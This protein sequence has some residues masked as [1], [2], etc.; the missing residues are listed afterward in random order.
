MKF[1]KFLTIGIA[2]LSVAAFSFGLAACVPEN[3]E[4]DDPDT[5]G[6]GTPVTPAEVT[7]E[8]G[9]AYYPPDQGGIGLQLNLY[10][11]GTFYYNQF[12]MT[13]VYGTYSAKE[14]TGTDEEGRTIHYEVTF[15]EGDDFGDETHYIVS[16]SEGSV[17]LTGMYDSMSLGTYEYTKQEEP[18]TEAIQTVEQFWS[19]NY[20][21]D[22]ITATFYSDD[23]YALDGINGAGQAGS[24]GTYT[25]ETAEDG[26]VTYTMTDGDDS[27]KVY[28]ITVVG[29]SI[30][31]KSGETEY[32][33]TS[34]NPMATVAMTLTGSYS[35]GASIVLTCYDDSTCN[36][37]I[38]ME[39]VMDFADATGTWSYMADEDMY[40]F[41]LNGESI[42]TETDGAGTYTLKYKINAAQ[43][44]G[45]EV[46]LTYKNE[47]PTVTY[48]FVY[49]NDWSYD[50]GTEITMTAR[51]EE[52]ADAHTFTGDIWGGVGTLTITLAADGTVVVVAD[53][54]SVG[55]VDVEVTTGTWEAN[56]D[57]SLALTINGNAYT[58][59]VAE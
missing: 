47:V 44:G 57:S 1:R 58:A 26:T 31:L 49:K 21:E 37:Q 25:S 30:T 35:W 34:I 17:Y 41:I 38:T 43:F 16:N 2:A 8:G 27:S 32:T 18:F 23:S 45:E 36:L 14:A 10:E 12:T 19:V 56:D 33:M 6:G 24:L 42:S 59:I 29:S 53:A 7:V 52:G 9:Y 15:D 4:A 13:I 48:T 5:P 11:D 28:T 3:E 20:E 50:L 40:V 39:G 46:T 22:F 54:E 51:S 55:A